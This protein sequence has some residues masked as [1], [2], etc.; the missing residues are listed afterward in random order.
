FVAG[1]N[2]T[3]F[4]NLSGSS[5]VMTVT[6]ISGVAYG[7]SA[8]Q[9]VENETGQQSIGAG[10]LPGVLNTPA[11]TITQ[12]DHGGFIITW[13]D[14]Y[15]S[16]LLWSPKLGSEANWQPFEGT[17]IHTNGIYQLSVPFAAGTAF[18]RMNP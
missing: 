1:N 3:A 11:L 14:T 10:I 16:Q 12:D 4:T 15:S 9:I 7:V 6:G 8:F 18:Y 5:Q 2:Y 17:P 13:P